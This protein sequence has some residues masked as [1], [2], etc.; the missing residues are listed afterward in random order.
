[1]TAGKNMM[2]PCDLERSRTAFTLIELL[3]VIAIIAIL[4]AMLLPALGKSK[5]K[6][7]MAVCRSNQKQIAYAWQMYADDN[8]D[9]M[10]ATV[11]NGVAY[12]GGGYFIPP[13]VSA[14][15]EKAEQYAKD[16]L[17]ASPLS[18]YAPNPAVFHCPGDLRYKNLKIGNGWAYAS[19]SKADGMNG[20][21]AAGPQTPYKKHNAAPPQSFVFIEES[22][23]RGFQVGT[24]LMQ[25]VNWN[26]G[27][28]IFHG[29]VTTF[30]FIDGHVES[31]KW[32]DAKTIQ[33]AQN[34]AN[35]IP[36]F[37]WSGGGASNPDF[38]WTWQGY[39]FQEWTP[40][41]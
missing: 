40:L 18:K 28:A 5:L 8:Q 24:W 4:A 15:P 41:P 11:I 13:D 39:R 9:V 1:M 14:N 27:F 6:A 10:M 26:D 16:A 38:V 23:P 30:S 19:Y 7:T 37:D 25:R 35:G 33:A 31:H 17:K 2:K 32:T 21:G 12:D 29:V 20:Y 3:V 22:D 36:S 34:M